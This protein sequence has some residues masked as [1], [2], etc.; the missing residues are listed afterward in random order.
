MITHEEAGNGQERR[1]VSVL[2]QT[3]QMLVWIPAGKFVPDPVDE[4]EKDFGGLDQVF[5]TVPIS[6]WCVSTSIGSHINLQ[7]P[8]Q[9]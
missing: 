3:F 2:Q 1:F 4:I 7:K 9:H 5:H 6:N 8:D